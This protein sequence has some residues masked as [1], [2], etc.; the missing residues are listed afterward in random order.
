M[1]RKFSSESGSIAPIFALS[2][3]AIIGVIAT[4]IALAADSKA[5]SEVQY[6]ADSAAIAGATAFATLDTP[7]ADERLK[8]ALQAAE[9]YAVANSDYTLVEIE[10]D[11]VVED[12]YGQQTQIDVE[13]EFQPANVMAR[14]AGRSGNASVRRRATAEAV[15]GF[16]LCIL[17]LSPDD[18]G[19]STDD[20]A[21]LSSKNC[22]VWSNSTALNSMELRGGMMTAKSFCAAG[23]VVGASRATPKAEDHCDAIPDPLADLGVPPPGTCLSTPEEFSPRETSDTLAWLSGF[24]NSIMARMSDKN[25]GG[26]AGGQAALADANAFLSGIDLGGTKLVDENGVFTTGPARGLTLEEL[27]QIAGDIDNVNPALY[28]GDNYS[29]APT[30]T[31]TPGTYC[32]GLDI[33]YG[34]LKMEPGVYHIKDGPLTVRRRGT[35]SGEGVTII[36]SGKAATFSILDEARLTLS[37]PT[38]GDT[39]GFALVED[40]ARHDVEP[41]SSGSRGHTFVSTSVS[42]SSS[43]GGSTS[44]SSW[45]W[46][47]SSS[48]ITR[49]LRSRLTGS[50]TINAIGTIYLP[51]HEFQ[52]SG[53]GAGEQASPLLQIVA[54]RIVMKENGKLNIDFDLTKTQVPAGIKPARFARLVN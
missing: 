7:K 35:L 9:D 3:T 51:H 54:N 34:H 15:W 44:S 36:L 13:L 45:S 38:G 39:A 23:G 53:S 10:L 33:A 29:A 18:A 32:G 2:I 4:A 12:A 40:V 6:T 21:Q 31:L 16:P 28:A 14:V 20:A 50:G 52:V 24:A 26:I 42:T 43:S 37:A 30:A 22:I 11:A 41:A 1:R 19:L 27:L 47:S 48:R 17:A 5:A 8:Q 49:P 46:S 25:G